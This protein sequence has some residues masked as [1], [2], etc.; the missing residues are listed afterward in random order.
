MESV[1]GLFYGFCT[2][3]DEDMER[4]GA[5]QDVLTII[6]KSKDTP[7]LQRYAGQQDQDLVYGLFF[8]DILIS[9]HWTAFL[10]LFGLL[11]SRRGDR[12]GQ[13]GIRK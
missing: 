1:P 2:P 9:L 4:K 10:S 11:A 6:T 12:A 5:T 13:V 8:W 3:S 7:A